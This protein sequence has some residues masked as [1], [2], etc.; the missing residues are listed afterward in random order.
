MKDSKNCKNSKG[1]KESYLK[2]AKAGNKRKGNIVIV[3]S[4][5]YLKK[6]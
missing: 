5:L 1:L 4:V 6:I 3:S 2:F